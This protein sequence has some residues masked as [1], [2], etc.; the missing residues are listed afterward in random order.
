VNLNF[1]AGFEAG[2]IVGDYDYAVSS[3]GGNII[4]AAV[5]GDRLGE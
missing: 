3:C 5:A 4:P 2:G 1:S